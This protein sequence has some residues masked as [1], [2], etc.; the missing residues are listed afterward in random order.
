MCSR[1][2]IIGAVDE[3]TRG[4][5]CTE[6]LEVGAGHYLGSHL[7]AGASLQFFLTDSVLIT[8]GVGARVVSMPVKEILPLSLR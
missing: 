3:P 1:L 5:M 8:G 2:H 7:F 6:D 4:G